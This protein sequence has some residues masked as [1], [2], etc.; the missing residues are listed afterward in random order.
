MSTVRVANVDSPRF[1][2]Y[3]SPRSI[4]SKAGAASWP[5]QIARLAKR[6]SL[7]WIEVY[8]LVSAEVLSA[9]VGSFDFKAEPLNGLDSQ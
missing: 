5:D 1:S 6:R 4:A 3:T 8:L 9:A 7:D 2:A